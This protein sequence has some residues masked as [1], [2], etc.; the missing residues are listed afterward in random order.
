MCAYNDINLT[1]PN[2]RNACYRENTKT[3]LG[4]ERVCGRTKDAQSHR[5]SCFIETL[6]QPHLRTIKVFPTLRMLR[7]K[8]RQEHTFWAIRV[9]LQHYPAWQ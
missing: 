1:Y 9:F 2:P 5:W 8:K 4:F 7:P 3:R 6:D